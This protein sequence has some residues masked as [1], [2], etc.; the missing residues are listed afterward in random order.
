MYCFTRV[1]RYAPGSMESHLKDMLD[2]M[3]AEGVSG[4]EM[5][6]IGVDNGADYSIRSPLFQ[7]ILLRLFRKNNMVVLICD[8]QAPYH[9]SWHWEIE[10]MWAAIRK[11]LGGVLMRK[12]Q[13][14]IA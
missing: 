13:P 10:S 5:G 2:A 9:S 1:V 6:L 3:E 12:K 11:L 7:H 4:S 14:K 8:A